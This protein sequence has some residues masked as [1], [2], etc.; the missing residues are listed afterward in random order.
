[1]G[2]L[3]FS[4]GAEELESSALESQ[5]PARASAFHGL[6]Y[7]LGETE[8]EPLESVAGPSLRARKQKVK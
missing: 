3:F 5:A 6:G 4:H 2:V 7:R 1:M 8:E